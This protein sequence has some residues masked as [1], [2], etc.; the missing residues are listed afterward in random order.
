MQ[1]VHRL[2]KL[3]CYAARGVIRVLGRLGRRD[4]G[5]QQCRRRRE[6]D[7]GTCTYSPDF[8]IEDHSKIKHT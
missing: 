7:E 5:T 4:G 1:L 8:H 6:A 2:L 3:L